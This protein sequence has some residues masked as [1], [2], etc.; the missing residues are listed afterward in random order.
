MQAL[1]QNKHLP[2]MKPGPAQASS[3]GPVLKAAALADIPVLPGLQ[4]LPEK[5]KDFLAVTSLW[6]ERGKPFF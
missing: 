1:R 5:R 3:T 6:L 4:T 2:E